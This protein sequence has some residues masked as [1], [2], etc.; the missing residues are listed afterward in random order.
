MTPNLMEQAWHAQ[1][2]TMLEN[3]PKMKA[4][5]QTVLLVCGSCSVFAQK[6]GW[7]PRQAARKCRYGHPQPHQMHSLGRRPTPK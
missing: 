4:L 2:I 3:I 1:Y 6:P 7:H 5:L